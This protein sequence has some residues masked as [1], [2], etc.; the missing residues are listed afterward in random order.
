MEPPSNPDKVAAADARIHLTWSRHRTPTMTQPPPAHTQER[1]GSVH[2]LPDDRRDDLCHYGV[3]MKI[4]WSMWRLESLSSTASQRRIIDGCYLRASCC[5]GRIT[6]RGKGHTSLPPSCI[7]PK[8]NKGEHLVTTQVLR[9]EDFNIT[10]CLNR[11]LPACYR[12]QKRAPT[13]RLEA[14]RGQNFQLHF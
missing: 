3:T 7:I 14:T 1:G 10:N 12:R 5:L 9:C 11:V 4:Y 13:N 2:G 6:A 8:E